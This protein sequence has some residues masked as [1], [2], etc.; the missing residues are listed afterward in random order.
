M[1]RWDEAKAYFFIGRWCP[2]H[3]GHKYI[4]DSYLKADLRVVVGIRDTSYDEIPTN[5][6]YEMI[7]AVYAAEV[8]S[9]QLTVMV[10]PDI[11]QVITGRGVGYSLARV[12]DEIAEISGTNVR[13][14]KEQRVPKE[15]QEI[16]D[17]WRSRNLEESK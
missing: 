16:Y 13:Q 7:A 1:P 6:R 12:P 3:E 15:A 17:E 8:L 14:G 5:L 11:A 4:V 2:F 10:I 9:G